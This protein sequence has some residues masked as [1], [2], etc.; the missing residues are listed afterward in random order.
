MHPAWIKVFILVIISSTPKWVDILRWELTQAA[1]FVFLAT[2]TGTRIVSSDFAVGTQSSPPICKSCRMS[3][4]GPCFCGTRFEWDEKKD[5]EN[6]QKHGV[7]FNPA[8][9][10]FADQNRLIA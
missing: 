9:Y 10:A 7:S 6:Q 2:T 3:P 8:R 1:M 5:H 4:N